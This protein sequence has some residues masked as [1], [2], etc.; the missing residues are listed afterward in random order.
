MTSSEVSR[1]RFLAAATVA[2]TL[3]A[4]HVAPASTERRWRMVTSWARTL[5][6]PG[7]S[8]RRLAD[9]I[10]ALSQGELTID[11]FAAGE[12]VPAL[13]VFDAVAAGTVE[14][15]HT[16]SVFWNGKMPAAPLFTT[17]PF[18]FDPLEH[19]SWIDTGAQALWDE[20]YASYRVRGFLAGNTGPSSGGWF[21]RDIA[22]AAD[23]KGLRIRATGLGAEVY[24]ALG[25][26]PI[27]IA[28][29][30][31]YAAFERGVI[32]AVELLAPANDLP[33]GLDRLAQ[34][35]M[36]PGFNKPNGASELLIGEAAWSSLPTRLQTLVAAACRGEHERA[37]AETL[38]ANA[39][40]L[41][42]LARGNVSVRW[43][44][45]DVLGSARTA[46]SSVLD[47]VAG[48]SPLA[49]RIV[50]HYRTHQDT[51]RQWSQ[52]TAYNRHF[53]TKS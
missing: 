1:R 37:L 6:G 50:T 36:F 12:L 30:D 9:S 45:A 10:T 47:R 40:A 16:A 34:Y 24:A 48:T 35:L 7:T 27:A 18:G 38:A 43:L 53:V 42:T 15:G 3:A 52:V 46:A 8:A 31:T 28:P 26:T 13:N 32:D 2:G 20:L 39:T 21:R 44:S 14:L 17:Q 25:A 5:P 49:G 4:P 41:A 51:L 11:V 33:S 23:F 19:V 29:S 22:S